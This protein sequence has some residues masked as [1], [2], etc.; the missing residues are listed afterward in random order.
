[1]DFLN[2]FLLVLGL[3]A[4]FFHSAAAQATKNFTHICDPLRYESLGLNMAD[5]GFC[6]KSLPYDVRVKILVDSM[7]AAEKVQQ[8]G[9]KASG[10][11][12]LGLPYYNWWSEALHGVS[13][14]GGGSHF[15]R[16]IPGATSFPEVINA[17]A[18]FNETLWKKTGQVIEQDMVET[19]Q[20][21]FEMCVKDG[22]VSAVMC[23]YNR[24][25]GIPTCADPRLLGQ[26]I[27][28]DWNL[29]GYIVS[30]CDSIQV[31]HQYQNW[32]NYTREEAVAQ[33]LR[34]GGRL[35]IT[36]YPTDYVDM[37]PMTSMPLRPVHDLGYPGRTYKFYNGPKV[38]PFGY[39]LSYTKFTTKL[40]SSTSSFSPVLPNNVHCH[41]LRST[42]KTY[43]R[44]CLSVNIEDMSCS[45][46]IDFEIEVTNVGGTS[47]SHVVL[48]YSVPPLEL[49]GYPMKQLVGYQRVFV[50]AGKCESVKFSLNACRSLAV[51]NPTAYT[52][53][54][55]GMHTITPVGSE[56]PP[57]IATNPIFG[58]YFKKPVV[59]RCCDGG[60]GDREL[61]QPLH[62]SR[63]G[64]LLTTGD[65]HA[66]VENPPVGVLGVLVPLVA[67]VDDSLVDREPALTRMITDLG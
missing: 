47:G 12:R 5:F 21:P 44:S 53:V 29:N 26:T 54:P 48:V 19:F 55:S 4:V 37:L 7:S 64:R 3:V 59:E 15:D 51:V 25:D 62:R 36:W 9:N 20:R 60:G 31:L 32:L 27:R 52:V 14:V 58:P 56:T 16:R 65:A 17:G 40:F 35:P 28:G 6:D 11:P 22:D 2:H 43:Q 10:V 66:E 30:D 45:E 18:T 41:P 42:Q 34:A 24:V 49:I 61:S 57:E 46:T 33:V 1:M 67:D 23:S 39:G 13:D 38:Y 63:S 8:L 50:G